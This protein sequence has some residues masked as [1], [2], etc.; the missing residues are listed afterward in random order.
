MSHV[1][2]PDDE[3]ER[4]Q[5]IIPILC[6]DVL[7]VTYTAQGQIAAVGLILRDTEDEG[8]GWCLV[9][10]RVQFGESLAEAATRHLRDTLG[11][12]VR[13]D[14]THVRQPLYVAQYFPTAREGYLVDPRKHAVA[15]TYALEIAGVPDPQNEALDFR[16]FPLHELPPGSAFGFGQDHVVAECVERL[17]SGRVSHQ[18]Q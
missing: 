15:L 11:G 18:S 7:P 13:F 9:G 3:W 4:I 17:L 5:R 14:A 10:G 1:W 12:D 6:V 8:Q 16:W 2:I